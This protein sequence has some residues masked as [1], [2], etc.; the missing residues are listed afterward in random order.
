VIHRR[1][2]PPRCQL[3]LYGKG[4]EKL[5]R[6][7]EGALL[8]GFLEKALAGEDASVRL[9]WEQ[10]GLLGTRA[11]A[12]LWAGHLVSP[13]GIFL[14]SPRPFRR[15]WV[16]EIDLPDCDLEEYADDV[17]RF[18]SGRKPLPRRDAHPTARTGDSQ[19]S[20]RAGPAVDLVVDGEEA[21]PRGEE[22]PSRKPE[23]LP[24]EKTLPASEEPLSAPGGPVG[25]LFALSGPLHPDDLR[26]EALPIQWQ[27]L[28]WL[29][30]GDPIR[31]PRRGPCRVLK[32]EKGSRSVLVKDARGRRLR[33]LAEELIREF[34]FDE[35]P[36]R[37]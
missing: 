20:T 5:E 14:R 25:D 34:R 31:S 36:A 29:N 24:P 26:G 33:I 21:A 22:F 16:L 9:S 2:K 32:V 35:E 18:L 23:V 13:L 8:E 7:L 28:E 37:D 19:R 4:R 17:V 27:D 12:P 1:K 6:P 10:N 30:P 11:L 3:L 15:E